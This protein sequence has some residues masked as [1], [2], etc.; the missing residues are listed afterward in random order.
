MELLPVVNF[1]YFVKQ[2]TK[3]YNCHVLATVTETIML[4]IALKCVI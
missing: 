1:L 4:C 2:H 3:I